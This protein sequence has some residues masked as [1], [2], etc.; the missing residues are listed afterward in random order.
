MRFVIRVFIVAFALLFSM[1]PMES[2]AF[3][4]QLP[5]LAHYSSEFAPVGFILD[6]TSEVPKLKFDSNEEILVLRWIPAAGGDRLLERD[7]HFVVLR[8]SGLG[9]VTLFTPQ[10]LRGVPVAPDRRPV[11]A[12]QFNAPTMLEVREYA[13]RIMAQARAET[14]RDVLFEANWDEAARNPVIRGLL[15]DSI[16]NA[17]SALIDWIRSGPGRNAIGTTL[18]RV[19]FAAGPLSLPYRQGDTFVIT[20]T[21][22]QGL[23]GRPTS[24]VIY[25]Q[26][27]QFA[28]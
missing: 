27:A 9:G 7:D 5:V 4:R 22:G 2:R 21:P 26:L 3:D 25:R 28:R 16:R 8:I 19:R 20:Y 6:L 1:G 23:A 11:Q 17:G 24:A 13:S 12:L 10:N 14:G 18:R 15:F